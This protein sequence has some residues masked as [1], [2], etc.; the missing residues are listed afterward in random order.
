MSKTDTNTA[1]SFD[2][3]AQELQN[4]IN[5]FSRSQAMIEFELDGTIVTANDNFCNALGYR[6]DEIQGRHH[7]Q[8]VDADYGNSPAYSQ[9]WRSLA[10]GDFQAG[11]FKRLRKDGSVIWIQASYNPIFDEKGKAYKV[12]KLASDITEQ[13]L[14]ALEAEAEANKV[15]Q[16]MDNMPINVMLC[17][18]DLNITYMNQ[19]STKTLKSI[20]HQLPVNVADMM[21]LNIDTFHE[22]PEHQ[23]NIIGNYASMLPR[24]VDI[25]IGE[26]DVGLQVDPVTDT[27]GNFIGAMA[28]WQIITEKKR[29]AA[30]QAA[31]Q[32]RE[33]EAAQELQNKVEQL[34]VVAEAAG[35]GDL[36]SEITVTGQ[37]SMGQLGDGL[38]NMIESISATLRDVGSGAN[39]IDSGAQQIAG[40]SQSLSEGASEQAAN[41]EEITASLEEMSSMTSQNAENAKQ[42]AILAEESQGSA[43][44]GQNEMGLMTEAMDEIKRSSAEISKIIK[45]IDEIAFQTNLLALNAAVEAARAGEAGKGFAVVAEEVR[46]LAQRSAEAAKNTAE[47]IEESSK[48][49]DNGVSIAARVGESLEEIGSSTQKV[50]TLLSEIAS[51][52]QEQSEGIEQVNRGV[53][54]LDKVTQLN[55]GNAEELASGA[56]ETAAQVAS[57]RD[58]IA[59]FQIVG[60]ESSAPA[61]S[62]SRFTAPTPT[63]ASTPKPATSR[64]N[65]AE[66]LPMDDDGFESF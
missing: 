43:D 9:F 30:E 15:Q 14:A 11:E 49:A 34:L 41:L 7:S 6:L 50:N 23:R 56:E 47:M 17:D 39:Q 62:P 37:D 59:Q 31:L 58:L 20:E 44:K 45:V 48:R 13:K 2:A 27:E 21:G 36:T 10:N 40:A 65:P 1:T 38:R 42:A 46:N 32:E 19:T 61:P 60:G 63:R 33:R 18:A 52:S 5:G 57:L 26:E 54:E 4:Q 55:A 25:K 16:M 3:D 35:Q 53:S 22:K 28:T 64:P 8:F 51:A 12:I 24:N 66:V 29:L